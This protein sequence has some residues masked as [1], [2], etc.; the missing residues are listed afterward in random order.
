VPAVG[1]G[2]GTF[3]NHDI[4]GALN[5]GVG[6]REEGDLDGL[7]LRGDEEQQRQGRNKQ[8]H[9]GI[10]V[11]L[12]WKCSNRLD[13]E[14]C[15]SYPAFLPRCKR[16]SY[17]RLAWARFPGSPHG[18]VETVPSAAL[19]QRHTYFDRW[20]ARLPMRPLDL[21]N[22]VEVLGK[23][24]VHHEHERTRTAAGSSYLGLEVEL[25]GQGQCLALA[26]GEAHGHRGA[27]PQYGSILRTLREHERVE[28]IALCAPPCRRRRDR[29][30]PLASHE[31][32]N[33]HF[34]IL[35]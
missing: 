25:F 16:E 17:F 30:R 15:R 23:S 18:A 11:S 29:A 22:R 28:F 10:L 3:R 9:G 31:P 12:F 33:Q 21:G 1:D 8:F 35:V 19:F 26:Q 27:K 20:F 2:A 14:R 7:G 4:P 6:V 13:L 24:V 5:E 32:L 34:H